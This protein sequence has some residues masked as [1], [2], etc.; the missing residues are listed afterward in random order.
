M[1]RPSNT[2]ASS[3]ASDLGELNMDEKQFKTL[4]EELD[5]E[6]IRNLLLNLNI[7]VPDS[8]SVA[9]E[10]LEHLRKITPQVD[11]GI[12]R[13]FSLDDIPLNTEAEDANILSPAYSAPSM[14]TMS[15]PPRSSM[16]RSSVSEVS[17]DKKFLKELQK[18]RKKT[19]KAQ[20]KEEKKY[21]KELQKQE[22]KLRKST[23]IS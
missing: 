6:T 20:A 15:P 11:I 7:I 17:V 22:K 1:S 21:L 18:E 3:L 2:S 8:A 14:N 5:P 16:S 19:L 4:A 23:Q 13:S 12:S 9:F 10:Y